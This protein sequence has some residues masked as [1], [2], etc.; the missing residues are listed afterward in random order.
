MAN[1]PTNVKTIPP[2]S[3]E[4]LAQ[5]QESPTSQ[6]KPIK[7]IKSKTLPADKVVKDAEALSPAITVILGVLAMAAGAL[8]IL[9]VANYARLH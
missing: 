6:K 5:I 2:I 8:T 4:I 9:V 3:P 7:A 1:S